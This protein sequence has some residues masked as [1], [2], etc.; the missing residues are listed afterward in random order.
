MSEKQDRQGARTV[1]DL[2]RR[3]NLGERFSEVMGVANDARTAAEEAKNSTIP[4][5]L[6]V[7]T[8]DFTGSDWL[9]LE[10]WAT[11]GEYKGFTVITRYGAWQGVRQEIS[12]VEGEIYT[13]S[14]Y[15]KGND[16]YF[17]TNN[18]TGASTNNGYSFGTISA[19]TRI[20]ITF[21]ATQSGT[22]FPRLESATDGT[23][24]SICGL[25]LEKGD[26]ATDW[27]PAPVDNTLTQESVFNA[28]TNNGSAQ[29]VY[30]EDGQVYINASYIKSGKLLAD[31]IKTG[32]ISSEDGTVQVDLSNNKV[33]IATLIN[34]KQGKIE[35][36]ASGIIGYGWDA[37]TGTYYKT[38]NIDPGGKNSSSQETLTSITSDS[39]DAGMVVSSG[40]E[41]SVLFL[42]QDLAETQICGSNIM[43]NYKSVQWKDNGDGTF[44]L[45]G[46]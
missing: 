9:N 44:T 36:S 32:I 17:F 34:G 3:L 19:W 39:S 46:T 22:L 13:F 24:M 25:K 33:V 31:L 11:D 7:G 12:A 2:E 38:L 16:I 8:K 41:G 15:V 21:T 35:L 40:K 26:K 42:G 43:I 10:S 29:G 20:S 5:N 28:L 23:V 45:I 1:S 30:R 37:A 18:G 14:A 6:L 4:A 27:S